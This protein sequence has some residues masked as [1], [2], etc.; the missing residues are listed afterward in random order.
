[1]P[2]KQYLVQIF[3]ACYGGKH[4]ISEKVV[5]SDEGI[6]EY[7]KEQTFIERVIDQVLKNHE[8]VSTID[9]IF[10]KEQNENGS[11]DSYNEL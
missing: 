8:Y 6:E 3:E 9:I 7:L 4:F 5:I 1:M 11:F 2:N 10:V